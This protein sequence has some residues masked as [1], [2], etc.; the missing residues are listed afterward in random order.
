MESEIE[1]IPLKDFSEAITAG[2]KMVDGYPLH[3]GDYAVLM[4]APL[5]GPRPRS[6]KSAG[7]LSATSSLLRHRLGASA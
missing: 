3:P 4:V 7:R 6:N 1:F 2:W 5:D